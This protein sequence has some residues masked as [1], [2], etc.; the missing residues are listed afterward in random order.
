M[1]VKPG[2]SEKQGKTKYKLF[3]Y[4]CYR[5]MLKIKWTNRI[6]NEEVLQ[7]MNTTPKLF[8]IIAKRKAATFG[9]V[10][11]RSSGTVFL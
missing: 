5:R 7:K 8:D 2:V 1:D 10:A 9:H 11:R 4:W 6:R 3:Y